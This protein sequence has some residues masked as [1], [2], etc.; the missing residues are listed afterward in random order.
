[1]TKCIEESKKY[2]EQQVYS[3]REDF[4]GEL[5]DKFQKVYL[6]TNENIK[7]Y[8]ENVDITN[9]EN[10]LSVLGSGD[11]IFNLIEKGI[12][13]IDTF[14]INRLT[15]FFVFGLKFA[16]IYKYN[17][18]EYLKT[19]SVII[20]DNASLEEITTII[21]DLLPHMSNKYRKYWKEINEFNY[22]LQKNKK[23]KINLFN[24]L[25]IGDYSIDNIIFRN[26]YL[27]DQLSYEAL[28][29]NL[30]K[31][32]F[33]FRN[34]NAKNLYKVFNKKYDLILMS[35]IIGFLCDYFYRYD[36]YEYINNM[37]NM[38][39]DDGML[40]LQYIFNYAN[41]KYTRENLF[42]F[43]DLNK[44]DLEPCEIFKVKSDINTAAKD[45]VVVLRKK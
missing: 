30:N 40:F 9:K 1:M 2:I 14:D 26:N 7:D 45:G 13:N 28:K 29:S 36:F 38:L 17:Y 24:L 27:T 37:R 15:E 22:K 41:E 18:K 16:M 32:N 31:I 39:T 43:S 12:L 25:G 33:T 23:N 8:I 11:H 20:N 42:L 34:I 3:N 35:N 19:L 21:N 6:T 5:F 10:A 4:Y 44:N